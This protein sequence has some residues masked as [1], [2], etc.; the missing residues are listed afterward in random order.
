MG[1]LQYLS[2]KSRTILLVKINSYSPTSC[3]CQPD[4]ALYH[5]VTTRG[6]Y[7]GIATHP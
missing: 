4:Y 5:P 6:A 1:Y 3:T 2:N 7:E